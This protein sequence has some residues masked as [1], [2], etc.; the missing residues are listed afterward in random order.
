MLY[1]FEKKNSLL[2]NRAQYQQAKYRLMNILF[3]HFFERLLFLSVVI[4]APLKWVALG[5]LT[6]PE[7][8]LFFFFLFFIYRCT[9]LFFSYIA[10]YI[11]RENIFIVGGI[12]ECTA[13]FFLLYQHERMIIFSLALLAGAGGGATTT[14]LVSMIESANLDV[15]ALKKKTADHDIFNIHLMLINASAF[16][17][18]FF[19]FLPEGIYPAT[20]ACLVIIVLLLFFNM[21]KLG[22]ISN[23]PH[24]FHSSQFRGHFDEKFF[25]IWLAT[26]S[27][28]AAASIVYAILPSLDSSFLGQEGM[29]IWL[30]FDALVVI[31]LFFILKYVYF[32][33]NN[34]VINAAIGLGAILAGLMLILIGQQ[35]FSIIL[36][37]LTI[38]AFGGYIA[39]GQLYGLAMQTPYLHRK[40]FYLGL[41]SFSGAM[42]E[43]GMQGLF[44]LTKSVNFCLAIAGCLILAGLL[45][46]GY[47]RKTDHNRH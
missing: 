6:G 19:A 21:M 40:T 12:I 2:D 29:N 44:W 36:L 34:S 13:I 1:L 16:L 31:V 3:M 11:S 27:V 42:G 10:R 35:S 23:Y 38:M 32:L 7:T 41:L 45:A 9:P 46:L 5:Y 18:P 8:G 47:L 22:K 26:I 4:V 15:S 30:S 25:L 39:F 37:A 28:W 20:I 33:R 24:V 14:M 43:A 17:S